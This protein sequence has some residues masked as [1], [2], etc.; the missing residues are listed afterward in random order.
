VLHQAALERAL[1]G[2]EVPVFRGGEQ[3]GSYRKYDERLTCF[4][5]ARRNMVGAQML[6]RYTA[7]AEFWS[8]RWDRMLAMVEHGP[9][10][11]PQE[12]GEPH[13][14]E[15]LEAFDRQ[16]ERQLA[17]RHAVDPPPRGRSW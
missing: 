5:L 17:I 12:D 9:A 16:V 15:S 11:W 3:V 4:L 6:G 14:A 10:L 2:V 13:T 8:E 1:H 7:G